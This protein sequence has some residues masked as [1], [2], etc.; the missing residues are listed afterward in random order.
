MDRNKN[1]M[2]NHPKHMERIRLMEQQKS[3]DRNYYTIDISH[4]LRTWI[5]RAWLI[6][7]CAFLTAVAGFSIAKFVI[8]PQYSSSIM[9]YVNNNFDE[10]PGNISNSDLQASQNLVKTYGVMLN[11]RSTLERVIEETK[12][13]YT[14]KQLSK[15][16]SSHPANETE[17]MVVTVTCGDPYEA[18]EIANGI[19]RVLPERISS[20][21]A[22][23]TME[24]VDQAVPELNKVSPSIAKYTVV[25]FLIGLF[26]SLIV[27][28]IIAIVDDTIQDDNYIMETYDYPILAKIPDLLEESNVKYSYYKKSSHKSKS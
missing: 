21:I 15:M 19:A 17:V 5:Q 22:G 3:N 11:N 6:I 2:C 9:L 20:I 14:Y 13:S 8:A 28:T 27:L 26:I 18:A 7:L 25:G 23:A 10:T 1:R 4:I 16:I 12:V 24:V